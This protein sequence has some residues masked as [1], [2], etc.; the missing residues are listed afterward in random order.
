MCFSPLAQ[1]QYA[2]HFHATQRNILHNKSQD[3][4]DQFY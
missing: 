3:D 1:K 2:R 4:C